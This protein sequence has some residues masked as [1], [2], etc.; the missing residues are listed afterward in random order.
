MLDH[1]IIVLLC[2]LSFIQQNCTE[3]VLSKSTGEI[4]LLYLLRSSWQ[5]VVSDIIIHQPNLPLSIT[6]HVFF[7]IINHCDIKLCEG[8]KMFQMM[9]YTW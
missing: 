8:M 9:L 1:V 7:E 4:I 3:S 5:L 6:A 2:G